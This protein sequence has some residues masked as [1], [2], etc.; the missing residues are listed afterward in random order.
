MK[1]WI[2]IIIIGLVVIAALH[3]ALRNKNATP[4]SAKDL[5]IAVTIFPLAD[6][7]KNIG[8]E[9]V[10]VVL[11]IPPG[12]TEHSSAL[13]PQTLAQLQSAKATFAVGQGLEDQ[14]LQKIESSQKI[15]TLTV[16]RGVTLRPFGEHEHG[17][18]D[19]HYWLTVPNAQQ[20]A[21]TMAE[22]LSKLDPAG[23]DLYQ[24]NLA[25]YQN[26]LAALEK[27]LQSQAANAKQKYFFPTHDGFG[28]FADHYGFVQAVTYEPVEGQEPSLQDLARMRGLVQQHNITVFYAEPQKA[29]SSATQFLQREFGLR[30]LTLDPVGGLEPGD[31][32]IQLM[33]R[34]MNAVAAG[35]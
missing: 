24:T 21:K 10:E 15:P 4:A 34:N 19:P 3:W 16:E 8:G 31:S 22:E 27:D 14:L 25:E 20:I 17:S 30:V 33:R 6:I 1:I 28:Y 26:Q 11:L 29:T 18:I 12:V 32:Y 7:I 2:A 13:T 35:S 23:S 9:R 5:T